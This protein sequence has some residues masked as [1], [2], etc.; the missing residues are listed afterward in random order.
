MNK[1]DKIFAVQDI[2][3]RI[4]DAKTVALADFRGLNVNQVNQLR[5][6]VR[7]VG[8]TLQVIKNSLL[9]RALNDN[10]YKVEKDDFAGQSIALFAETDEIAPLKVM[11]V[12]AKSISLLPFKMGFMA[13]KI[14][15]AEELTKFAS[16]P[17]KIELQAKLVSMLASQP[18]R[19][20]YA[21]NWN[22]QKLVL[23]IKE[24]SLK[25]GKS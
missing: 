24:V 3:A 8:G 23:V 13:G 18:S 9:A 12:F 7:E 25:N 14:L 1:Q 5:D 20:V 6:R 19:L 22:L 4:K 11:A 15:T 17:S 10:D 16:L 21:L 2:S